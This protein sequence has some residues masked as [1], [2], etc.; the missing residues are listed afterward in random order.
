[1]RPWPLLLLALSA[2]AGDN[3]QSPS[4]IDYARQARAARLRGDHPV[5]LEQGLKALALAPDN[6]DLLISVARAQAA[7]GQ[8]KEAL[9]KLRQAIDRGAGLDITLVPEFLKLPPSEQLQVLTERSRANLAPVARAQ[10]FAVIPDSTRRSEGIAYDPFSRHVFAGTVHGEIL[11]IDQSGVVSVLVP[12]DQG[13]REV[14]GIKVDPE[15]RL[16]WAATGTFPDLFSLEPQKPEAGMAGVLAYSLKDGA[17]VEKHW[18]DERPTLHGFND[19]ALAHNGDVYVTDTPQNAVYRLR[20]GRLEV[21]VRD[22]RMTLVNG[23]ALAPDQKRLYV[24]HAEGI[25]LVDLDSGKP[26]L[27][28]TPANVSVH[29]IDGLAYDRG[30]LIG[31]QSSPYLARVIRIEL[32]RDGRSV[33]RTVTLNARSPAEYSQTTAAVADGQLYVVAG[34]PAVDSAGKPLAKE[35]K[36]QILRIPLENI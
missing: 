27:L 10:L 32:S 28:R 11:R 14:L 21:L 2:T 4:L 23:I 6:P 13:L 24:A 30:A 36:P 29:S 9:Q 17:L 25:S 22:N 26:Q 7:L 12:R 31:V 8:S 15:R 3:L 1:M 34:T 33:V 5:W 20:R 16:I 19:L 35:P 18:M